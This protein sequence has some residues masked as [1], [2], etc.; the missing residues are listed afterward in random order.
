M[1]WLWQRAAQTP[2]KLALVCGA[3]RLRFADL[4]ARA[5]D[6]AARLQVAGLGRGDRLALRLRPG[7]DFAALVHA[8]W[9][10][11]AI[12]APLNLR[13][14]QAELQ[15]QLARIAPRLILDGEAVVGEPPASLPQARGAA[16]VPLPP[17][18]RPGH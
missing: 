10:I 5:E 11:G 18:L 9:R 1:H 4:A 16:P 6:W 15:S 14:A 13:L 8:A 12:A 17:P 2:E 7:V 3:E